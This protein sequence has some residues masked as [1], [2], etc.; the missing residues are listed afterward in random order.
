MSLQAPWQR[1]LNKAQSG[2]TVSSLQRHLWGEIIGG[3][4]DGETFLGR[5]VEPERFPKQ[6]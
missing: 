5:Q 4:V 1:L 6:I 3:G 2:C